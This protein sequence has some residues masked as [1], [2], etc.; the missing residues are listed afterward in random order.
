MRSLGFTTKQA[1]WVLA[2]AL[3]CMWGG[4]PEYLAY[5]RDKPRKIAPKQAEEFRHSL[6]RIR[7]KIEFSELDPAILQRRIGSNPRELMRFIQE[8]IEFEPYIGV[9]RGARG[10]LL[11]RAGNAADR[12]LLLA[13]LFRQAGYQVRFAE[14]RLSSDQ[15]E[16]LLRHSFS[17]P[18]ATGPLPPLIEEILANA[19]NHFSLL[20]NV[21]LDAGFEPP[22]TAAQA[23]RQAI[24]ETQQHTWVQIAEG[25]QWIDIDPSPEAQFAQTLV[26]DE[27]ISEELDK[28]LFHQIH[29]SL[30]IEVER[31]GARQR[32]PILEFRAT[33]AELGG[34]PLGLFHAIDGER[35]TAHFIVGDRVL[36]SKPFIVPQHTTRSRKGIGGRFDS[37]TDALNQL[38]GGP[39]D[40]AKTKP[41]AFLAERLHVRTTGP[42]ANRQAA[43]AIVNTGGSD[44]VP[45]REAL[46][47][48]FGI[49]VITGTIAEILPAA[50]LSD[51]QDP[52][53]A[54][55]V[56]KM[57]AALSFSYMLLRQQMPASF[58]QPAYRPYIDSPNLLIAKARGVGSQG[59]IQLAMDLTLKGYRIVPITETEQGDALLFYNYLVNGVIDHIVERA[60][61]G[62]SESGHGV[63]ALFEVASS[64]G[65]GAKALVPPTIVA[66]DLDLTPEGK[67]RLEN[68][69][70]DGS[71]I[72]I[73]DQR[74]T[75]WESGRLGWWEISPL[76]GWTQDT[77]EV[78]Y[79]TDTGEYSLLVRIRRMSL[80]VKQLAC[81]VA[82]VV[83]NTGE[84]VGELLTQIGNPLGELVSEVGDAFAKLGK[85]GCKEKVKIPKSKEGEVRTLRPR[86]PPPR[87]PPI[88]PGKAKSGRPENSAMPKSPD[89]DNRLSKSGGGNW[90]PRP[91]RR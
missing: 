87:E 9:L 8:Q 13:Q 28:A 75:G 80:A 86:K 22:S 91:P 84:V 40:P 90:G 68:S 49:S 15:A 4:I 2:F 16:T 11:A 24:S 89:Y 26:T 18:V 25:G 66:F 54:R 33:A 76:T 12:A 1:C 82:V 7:S 78:G 58:F 20:G 48:I 46:N 17:L 44:A 56:S 39:S 43:H 81:S 23:W 36:E 51:I 31:A 83:G 62:L 57:L 79:H 50:V 27:Q 32:E 37:I 52:F 73:P 77:T 55:G 19:D 38:P 6:E 45:I 34:I 42:L 74:P 47:T 21:L 63:G 10:T 88:P 65:I 71:I 41:Y 35:V 53:S 14:G 3:F 85:L 5:A 64:Q 29:F 67:R 61:L 69:V 30:E 59:E 72:V 60:I 70:S